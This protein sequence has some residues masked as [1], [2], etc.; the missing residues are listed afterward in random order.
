MLRNPKRQKY[1]EPFRLK[2]LMSLGGRLCILVQL[3]KCTSINRCDGGHDLN[4]VDAF[5][6]R[7]DDTRYP[8]IQTK[9]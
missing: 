2:S 9:G 7:C 8:S 1:H 6:S 5:A 4:P 3:I